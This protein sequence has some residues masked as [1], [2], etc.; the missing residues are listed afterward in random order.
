MDG[1][2]DHAGGFDVADAVAEPTRLLREL[3]QSGTAFEHAMRAELGVNATD[4]AAMEHLIA[5][6]PL[7]PGELSRR[8]AIST[9][10]T[11]VVIDRLVDAGHAHR[12]PNPRDRR[13]VLVVAAPASIARAA[14]KLMPLVL[15]IDRA[16]DDFE[17]GERAAIARYLRAVL[18]TYDRHLADD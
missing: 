14:S 6:G 16:L 18:R 17:P 11:T 7:P 1:S 12:E 10:S 8:L 9:A 3:L 13:S 5:D 2:G 15:E 4:L